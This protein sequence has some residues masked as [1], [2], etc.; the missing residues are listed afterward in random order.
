MQES[1]MR[2]K[3]SILILCLALAGLHL[4]ILVAGFVAP[5]APAA[6]NRELSY[7]PPTRIHFVDSSAFHWRPYVYAS[8]RELDSY[9]EDREHKYPVHFF[10]RGDSYRLLWIV[11]CNLHLFGVD[12]PGRVLLFGTDG[13]GRDE[14]SRLIYGGRISLAA[15]MLATFLSLTIATLIGTAS[16]Y[17]SGWIDETLMGSSELFLS[18]PWFYFLVALRSFLPLHLSPES[19]FLLLI[20]VIGVVGWARPARLV[21][22]IVLSARNRNYVLAA[23]GFGGSDFY[24]LRRHVLPEISGVLLTQAALLI[25]QYVA[26]EA[27]LSFFG[28][29]ISE[30]V[31]SWGNMLSLLQQYSV[32]VSY[33]WLLAP[34]AALVVTSVMYWLLADAIHQWVQSQSM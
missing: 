19:T 34:A 25:P 33:Y 24:V 30:P 3:S 5:Y 32:L 15:G 28:L 21:R 11:R 27:T 6:Q 22:G 14:L 26:A 8:V 10:V 12:Q 17:Y 23:Q 16:G 29:G 20:G 18:L 7:A 2:A 4:A 9:R 13:Y 1:R 31:A